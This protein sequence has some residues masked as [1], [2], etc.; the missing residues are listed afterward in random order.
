MASTITATPLPD[1]AEILTVGL[2]TTCAA[3][4]TNLQ[5]I[6][7][8]N[9][10]ECFDSTGAFTALTIDY[11]NPASDNCGGEWFPTLCLFVGVLEELFRIES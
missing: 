7:T 11:S 9:A 5:I 6:T 8:A 3:P 1:A 10:N 4:S 2:S